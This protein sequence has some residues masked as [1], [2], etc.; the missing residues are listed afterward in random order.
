MSKNFILLLIFL[1]GRLAGYVLTGI[2]AWYVTRPVFQNILVRVLSTGISYIALSAL[3]IY[4]CM[5]GKYGY[6]KGPCVNENIMALS[7]GAVGMALS[8]GFFTAVTP[9]PPFLIAIFE[10]AN[11][12]GVLSAVLFFVSFFV[13]TSIYFLF[14]PFVGS[15]CNNRY[16]AFLARAASGLVGYY[17]M[18]YGVFW[19]IKG[20][21]KLCKI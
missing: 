15:I 13:G 16:T 19:T 7:S 12:P 6:E 2:A 3:L 9:C 18:Y 14:I 4:F 21:L 5:K 17:Y 8:L 11:G 20:V 1:A 10:V